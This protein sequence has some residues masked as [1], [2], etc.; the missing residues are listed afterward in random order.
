MLITLKRPAMSPWSSTF[1]LAMVRLPDF[2]PA[3]SARIGAICLHGPHHSAQKSTRMGVEEL[4]T[5]SSRCCS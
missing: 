4:L 2:S 1:S 3:I 5:V